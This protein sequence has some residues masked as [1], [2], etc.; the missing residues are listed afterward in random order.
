[1]CKTAEVVG[2]NYTIIPKAD[3]YLTTTEHDSLIIDVERDRWYWNSRN[4]EGNAYDWLVSICGLTSSEAVSALAEVVTTPN[5]Q[6]SYGVEMQPRPH[7]DLLDI[8]WRNGR[9]KRDF[10]YHR[11]YT[12]RTID[13][14][15]LGWT[16]KFY[17]IPIMVDGVLVNFQCRTPEKRI[18]SWVK[19][20]A[21]PF[22][23]SALNGNIRE[24]LLCESPVD[25]IIATQFGYKAISV[26]PNIAQWKVEYNSRLLEVGRLTVAADND[27][28]GREYT[29]KVGKLLPGIRVNVLDW[30]GFPDRFD[31]GDVLKYRGKAV[32][33]E[34]IAK[35]LPLAAAYGLMDVYRILREKEKCE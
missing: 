33:D 12:D 35:A 25:A 31:V 9:D 20:Y 8:F 5:Y 22:N 3:G 16:G 18:W 7:P 21:Q 32:M 19:G 24:V 26:F 6:K 13:R 29:K 4:L 23:F 27:K 17:T 30:E 28:S 11:G 34:L 1:M 15:K 2:R 10:W 14:F